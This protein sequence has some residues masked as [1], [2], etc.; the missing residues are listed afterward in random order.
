MNFNIISLAIVMG[1]IVPTAVWAEVHLSD[2]NAES[3]QGLQVTLV[4]PHSHWST[5]GIV[6]VDAALRNVSD[7]PFLVDTFGDLDGLY[8]RK[9]W[10]G[11]LSSCWVLAWENQPSP[12]GPIGDPMTLE[13]SQFVLLK[14]GE[15]YTKHLSLKLSKVKPGTYRIRLAYAPR[16]A[17]PSFSFPT[18][19][20]EQHTLNGP[21]WLGMAF[22]NE[23]RVEVWQ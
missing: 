8:R 16:A 5:G 10:S 20:E 21:M 4:I 1:A 7:R 23:L 6:E 3:V 9:C 11:Y 18:K 12:P 2:T 14:P 13:P 15:S 19:W 17:S 22:S